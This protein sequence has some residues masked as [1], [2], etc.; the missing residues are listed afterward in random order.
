MTHRHILDISFTF[1]SFPNALSCSRFS[2]YGCNL[3]S[4][5]YSELIVTAAGLNLRVAE[6][7]SVDAA[8]GQAFAD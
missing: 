4:R 5:R 8:S 3:V 1:C 6:N 7:V 2:Q